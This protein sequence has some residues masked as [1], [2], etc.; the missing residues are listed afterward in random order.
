[1]KK[2]KMLLFSIILI[3]IMNACLELNSTEVAHNNYDITEIT[4]NC[5]YITDLDTTIELETS[6]STLDLIPSEIGTCV[7]G[8]TY[9]CE[10]Y[11]YNNNTML[12]NGDSIAFP[13]NDIYISCEASEEC[14]EC[15]ECGTDDCSVDDC[16]DVCEESVECDSCCD[17]CEDCYQD[18][19]TVIAPTDTFVNFLCGITVTCSELQL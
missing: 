19:D 14:D 11:D 7:D 16:A 15:G 5:L 13:N 8:Q 6:S 1:M 3:G 17:T 2:I 10:Y 4:D 18:L 9:E 12:A